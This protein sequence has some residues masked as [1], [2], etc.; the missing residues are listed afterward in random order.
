M[1]NTNCKCNPEGLNK[2]ELERKI[3]Y[4]HKAIIN[5]KGITFNREKRI[6]LLRTYTC[7]CIRQ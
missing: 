7:N 5:A 2:T 3:S 4:L 6:S 1:E